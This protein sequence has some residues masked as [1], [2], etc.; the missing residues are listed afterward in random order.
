L[1]VS[2]DTISLRKVDRFFQGLMGGHRSIYFS[3]GSQKESF[4]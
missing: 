2:S 4:T 3:T 1:G